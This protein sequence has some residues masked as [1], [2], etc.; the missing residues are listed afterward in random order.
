MSTT[1]VV[2]DASAQFSANALDEGAAFVYCRWGNPTVRQLEHKLADLE[3]GE[4][5]VAFASGM[6]AA[7][8]LFLHRLATGDHLI[9][10]DVAYAGVSELV[11]QTLPRLGI[12]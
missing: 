6:A 9:V 7:T 1:Y 10:S 4:A 5:A 3:Q 8:A 2:S 11:R 12:Q